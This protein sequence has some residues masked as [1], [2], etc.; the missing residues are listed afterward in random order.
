MSITLSPTPGREAARSEPAEPARNAPVFQPATDIW[1]TK[2]R[3]IIVAEIPGAD[4]DS[5]EARI[6]RNVLRIT[7]RSRMTR[8][9][10]YSLIHAEYRDGDYE[11]SF[12]LPNEI[13]ADGIEAT[14]RDGLLTLV[15]PKTAPATR[16]IAIKLA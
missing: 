9:A 7:A 8:P 15:L 6:D 5:V 4:P 11:R 13:D 14:V 10:G 12:A 2:D 3:L 16:K 1:E